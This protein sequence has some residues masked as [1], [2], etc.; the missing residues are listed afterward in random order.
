M[1][2]EINLSLIIAGLSIVGTI[3]TAILF[4]GKLRWDNQKHS[5]E[6]KQ[7]CKDLNNMG[8]KL[9][10]LKDLQNKEL[11]DIIQRIDELDKSLI[12]VVATLEH[13]VLAVNEIKEKV[14]ND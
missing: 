4:F 12:K 9:D 14:Y 13:V 11:K 8:Q 5:E 7:H 6:I 2:V 10:R 1:V 3:I